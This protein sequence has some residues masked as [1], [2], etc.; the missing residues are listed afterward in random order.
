[1]ASLKFKINLSKD[2]F[3]PFANS[4]IPDQM[5]QNAASD[6]GLHCL[7]K[8]WIFCKVATNKTNPTPLNFKWI[9]PLDMSKGIFGA[10][11]N[12]DPDQT[13]QNAVS[14]FIESTGNDAN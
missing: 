10:L 4:V 8:Y 1:M 5:P 12:G 13:T 11:A 14:V 3:E 7:P 6:Q 9:C 2:I